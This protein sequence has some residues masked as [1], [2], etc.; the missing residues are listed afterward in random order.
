MV[1]LKD[2]RLRR[3]SCSPID[4]KE[5]DERGP[6]MAALDVWAT[7]LA[8]LTQNNHHQSHIRVFNR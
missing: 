4:D 7:S 3:R 8:W 6:P 1:S 2:W 5:H